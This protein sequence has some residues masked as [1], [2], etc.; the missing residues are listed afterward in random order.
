[1]N[2]LIPALLA[3]AV[4]T[5]VNFLD[6]IVVSKLV[7]DYRGMTIY[8]TIAGFVVGTVFWIFTGFPILPLKDALI[9]FSTGC[10]TI[11][12]SQLYFKAVSLEE[13]SKLILFFQTTPIFTMIIAFLL[14][15]EKISMTQFVG[16]VTILLTVIWVSLEKGKAKF[17]ISEASLLIILVNIMWALGG[18]LIK[19][20]ISANSFA[21]ILSYESWGLGIGGTVLY[22]FFP[23][24]RNAFHES[25][26]TAGKKTL[27]VMFSNEI[28]FVIGKSITFYAYTIGTA[29]LVSVVGS[30]QVFF[31]IIF[32]LL[33]TKFAPK[34]LKED[35]SKSELT[36]KV[37]SAIILFVGL[38][39][40]YK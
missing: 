33:L 2:W 25:F 14:L 35:V 22:L 21:S 32:G 34:L 10:L 28:I 12:G 31:G 11:W 30:T 13:P 23:S 18:V 26:R 36:K 1:M 6:K 29:T 7:K 4:Y 24:I 39:L 9:I 8:G 5:V 3:P 38:W 37:V 17:Q 16:F 40:V 20:A 19:F 27:V 15:G